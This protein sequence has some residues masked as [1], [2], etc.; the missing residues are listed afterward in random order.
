MKAPGFEYEKEIGALSGERCRE[1]LLAI[2]RARQ[3]WW[4]APCEPE[5]DGAYI[6]AV[7]VV[8]HELDDSD[9]LARMTDAYRGEGLSFEDDG[10]PERDD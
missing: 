3:V 1:M 2:A 7:G 10:S 5:H 8:F 9:A 4:D 6:D